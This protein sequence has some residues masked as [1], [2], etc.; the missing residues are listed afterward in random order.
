M[1]FSKS[2]SS[3]LDWTAGT[4]GLAATSLFA[5]ALPK[6]FGMVTPA[7]TEPN[8]RIDNYEEPL[9]KR[10]SGGV[11]ELKYIQRVLVLVYQR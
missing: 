2:K 5:S 10:V 1:N 4:A 11:T 8:V 9:V 7:T 6:N 3:S